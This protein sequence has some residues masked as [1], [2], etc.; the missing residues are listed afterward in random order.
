MKLLNQ[1]EVKTLYNYKDGHLYFTESRGCRKAGDKVGCYQKFGCTT[2][3]KRHT[4]RISR[5]I[6]LYHHGYMPEYV[7]HIDRN[8]HNNRIENLIPA[9]RSYINTNSNRKTTNIRKGIVEQKSGLFQVF[10]TKNDIKH[11]LGSFSTLDEAIEARA[12]FYKKLY[13]E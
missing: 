7:Y 2:K 11:Y 10:I 6:F 4:Y 8:V 12:K 9:S 3:I 13:E 1:L 5:L